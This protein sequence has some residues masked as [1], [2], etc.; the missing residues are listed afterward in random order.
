MLAVLIDSA[1]EI[2]HTKQQSIANLMESEKRDKYLL[3]Y[4]NFTSSMFNQEK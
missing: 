3:F 1:D 2:T 4:D